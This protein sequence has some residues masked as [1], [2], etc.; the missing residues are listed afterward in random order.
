M[1]KILLI[2]IVFHISLVT[3]SAQPSWTKKAS[4]SVFTLKTFA[5][6]GSLIASSN[7]FFVGSQGEAVSSFS[8]FKGA[9][10]AI[11]IDT[12][13]KELEVT[14]MMGANEMYDVAKFRVAG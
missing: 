12:S 11:V 6:D 4:K 1:K 8:P 13:G 2:L 9:V 10:R 7:G 14:G 3:V 5:D